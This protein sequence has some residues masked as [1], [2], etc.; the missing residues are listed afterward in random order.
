MNGH[1][2]FLSWRHPVP[3]EG[4]LGPGYP[5]SRRDWAELMVTVRQVFCQTALCW[6]AVASYLFCPHHNPWGSEGSPVWSSYGS[7]YQPTEVPPAMPSTGVVFQA[8]AA[9]SRYSPDPAPSSQPHG[10]SCQ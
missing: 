10:V 6:R 8:P 2:V 3:G 1:T 9:E 7:L 4:F 5:A